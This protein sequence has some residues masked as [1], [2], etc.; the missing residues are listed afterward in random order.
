MGFF[1]YPEPFDFAQGKLVEGFAKK[2]KGSR[3]KKI[4]IKL[5]MKL[6]Y[7]IIPLIT[8]LTALSGSLLT[9]RGMD[10][11]KTIVKPSWTP[12]GSL[13]GTVWTILFILGAIS[14]LI[15]WN[16]LPHDNRFKWIIAVFIINAILNV[17]WS[18]LF[19]NQHLLLT[20]I[21][22]AALLGA[23]V[24]ALVILIWPL[25][26]LAASLLIP[27]AV[28]VLFATFLTYKVWSLN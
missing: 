16:R 24:V 25:S 23:S 22:E 20:A 6:N 19:F 17:G 27:Y 15:V 4:S 18:F 8:F 13:I 1:I 2:G 10:W 11:Y 7:I 9:S 21:F 26:R 5:S 28:W 3:I 14:A 12:A